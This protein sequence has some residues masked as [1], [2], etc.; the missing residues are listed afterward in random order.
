MATQSMWR[1]RL[2]TGLMLSLGLVAA[3]LNPVLTLLVSLVFAI[4]GLTRER[5]W[6]WTTIV[7]FAPLM[8]I[9]SPLSPLNLPDGITFVPVD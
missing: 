3:V 6:R 1:V 8:L 5:L 4:R 2:Q 9:I 7:A